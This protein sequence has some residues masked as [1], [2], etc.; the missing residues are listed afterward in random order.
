MTRAGGVPPS[1]RRTAHGE[2]SDRPNTGREALKNRKGDAGHGL[3]VVTRTKR[4][5]GMVRE[6]GSPRAARRGRHTPKGCGTRTA[7][8]TPRSNC[9]AKPPGG[10]RPGPVTTA[11]RRRPDF[12]EPDR[13]AGTGTGERATGEGRRPTPGRSGSSAA[14]ANPG[15]DRG[16][17]DPRPRASQY[18]RTTRSQY[19]P[20]SR[21]NYPRRGRERGLP[22]AAARPPESTA[23]L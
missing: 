15:S 1:D 11:P 3:G 23:I 12:R 2:R 4:R 16:S 17:K 13:P 7:R 9:P 14:A 8:E 6:A 21:A 20:T 5:S 18:A 22:T 19:S 10:N